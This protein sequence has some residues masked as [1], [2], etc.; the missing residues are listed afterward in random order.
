MCSKDNDEECLMHS[1]SDNK[2]MMM[3][4]KEDEVIEEL[5]LS[6]LSKNQAGLEIAIK[7]SHFT[8]DCVHLLYCKC[9]QINLNCVGSYI[10]SRDWIKRKKSSNKCY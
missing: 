10:D 7:D 1:K 4:N 3:N 6:L 8:F 5:F 9:H 2:E